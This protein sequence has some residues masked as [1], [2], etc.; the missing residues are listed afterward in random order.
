M[1]VARRAT[2]WVAV[3]ETYGTKRPKRR[4]TPEGSP[5]SIRQN[6]PSEQVSFV[7]FDPGFDQQFSV[8][9]LELER[10]PAVMFFLPLDVLNQ[11]VAI[12]PRA[13]K[14][15]ISLL[16]VRKALEHRVLLDPACGTRLD[17]LDEIGQAHRG[18]ETGQD[19]KVILHSVDAIKMALAV[20][21]DSPDVAEEV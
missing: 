3:G 10:R 19:V 9:L 13:G 14:R 20:A 21:D 2:A 12:A 7:E 16:P 17:L 6:R 18:M 8:F 15:C 1:R 5:Q 4:T 11:P